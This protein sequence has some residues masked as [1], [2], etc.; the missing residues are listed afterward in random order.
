MLKVLAFPIWFPCWL[1][2]YLPGKLLL[3]Y[4]YLFPG[5]GQGWGSGR[6]KN[7]VFAAVLTSIG[8]WI[9]VFFGL[10][11]LAQMKLGH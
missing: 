7:S 5:P 11:I 4:Q 10:A 9:A 8:L 3:E 1:L 6:R 2:L